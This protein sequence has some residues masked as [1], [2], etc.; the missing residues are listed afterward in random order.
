MYVC[1]HTTSARQRDMVVGRLVKWSLRST[2]CLCMVLRQQ[3]DTPRYHKRSALQE[4]YH[5]IF[6]KR[7]RRIMIRVGEVVECSCGTIYKGIVRQDAWRSLIAY[8]A[9]LT[10]ALSL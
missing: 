3:S 10:C 2:N 9:S 5:T 8:H 6:S 4:K 1:K 7:H